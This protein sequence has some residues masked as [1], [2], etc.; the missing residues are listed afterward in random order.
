MKHIPVFGINEFQNESNG[1]AYFYANDLRPHLESHQ[2][3]NAPHSHSTYI[4]VFFTRGTGTHQ[5]D[6][7]EYPVTKGSIFLLNPGQIHSWKLSENVEGYVIFHTSS[8]YNDFYAIHKIDEFPF[9]FL[10]KNYPLIQI[11]EDKI[12][13]TEV[14]FRQIIEEY[15]TYLPQKNFKISSLL[16]LIYIELLRLYTSTS[17]HN[18]T[19]NH[20]RVRR[21]QKLIDLNF[22]EKKYSKDYSDMMNMSPR[23]LTRI[24]N[25]TLNSSTSNLILNR[26][27][28]EA[29][30]LLIYSHEP[31]S[32]IAT[33]LGYDDISY[34]I[35][36]FKMKTGK[37]PKEFRNWANEPSF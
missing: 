25:E 16:N 11:P 37:S 15:R 33:E 3:V 26:I 29:K 28:L 32:I 22:K 18:E 14:L 13:L 12:S 2:F 7:T 1:E 21:L 30:R 9:Y 10:S 20:L 36:F 19:E 6:F 5:I 24:C 31:I 34:F 4:M 35:R 27:I 23:H 8:F 17:L